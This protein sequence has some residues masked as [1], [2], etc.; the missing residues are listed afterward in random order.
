MPNKKVT[1]KKTLRRRTIYYDVSDRPPMVIEPDKGTF[2]TLATWN[3]PP[4]PL[5]IIRPSL[6][7]DDVHNNTIKLL[8]Y[9][10]L[11]RKL[12]QLIVKKFLIF[13]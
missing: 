13:G 5:T 12:Q 6:T 10:L 4:R 2:D 3:P 11:V 7:Y 9:M 8:I 1:R